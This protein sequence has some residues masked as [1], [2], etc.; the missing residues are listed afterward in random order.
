MNNNLKDLIAISREY[1]TDPRWVVAGGGNTSLKVDDVL[2][3]KASGYPLA[4]IGEE[5]FARMDRSKLAAIWSTDYP[6]GEDKAAVAERERLVLADMMAARMPGEDKRPSVEAL[7]H[8][9]LPW[10]LIVHLHPTLINGLTCGAKGKSLAEDIFRDAQEWIPLTDPGYVLA[11]KIR[12][13]L[14]SRTARGGD[15]PD[16][17]F[18]ANHGVF[19]GGADAEEIRMKYNRLH[20]AL[21]EKLSRQPDPMPEKT[22]FPESIEAL[23]GIAGEFFGKNLKMEYLSGGELDRYLKNEAAAAALTGSLTPDHI[24]YSGPGAL[25]IDTRESSAEWKSRAENYAGYW[26][27][28]PNIFLLGGHSESGAALVAASGKKALDNAVLLLENALAVAAYS[29]S[30]GGPQLMEEPSVRFIV[31]W[32]VENYRS[33]L[34]SG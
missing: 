2:Y 1:G 6:A 10:P 30:F 18:L 31:N 33:R 26:G 19:V 4:T 20:N 29:E 32:E 22:D 12:D 28:P 25:F 5:G 9:L 24:V 34:A 14:E 7:L 13:A 27:K 15:S 21:E 11:K 23:K 17:I 8:D 16:F 3:V